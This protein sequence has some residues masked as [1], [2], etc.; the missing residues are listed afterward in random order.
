MKKIILITGAAGMVGSNLI[1]KYIN[2][3][4][5]IIAIDSLKLGKR[6]FLK[7]FEKKKNFLFF[8]IYL[9]KNI[10]DIKI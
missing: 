2:Q 5:Q 4:V 10:K 7:P 6:K 8:K 9:S 3:D 1:N